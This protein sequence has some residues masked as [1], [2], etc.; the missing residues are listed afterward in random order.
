MKKIEWKAYSKQDFMAKI[1]HSHEEYNEHKRTGQVIYL[2]QACGKLF[3]AV[4][5]YLMVKYKQR[6]YSY[7]SLIQLISNNE[8]D[9]TLL[10]DAVQLHYFYYNGETHFLR[11]VADKIYTIV[12]RKMLN[13]I[14]KKGIGS[15]KVGR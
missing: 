10:N 5:N 7:G 4:E 9:R 6:R 2:Q 14:N 13:R 3:S 1:K 15:K 8:K 12:R 11:S